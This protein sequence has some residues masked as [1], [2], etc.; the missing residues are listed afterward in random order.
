MLQALRAHSTRFRAAQLSSEALSRCYS[1][2]GDVDDKHNE[3]L[4]VWGDDSSASVVEQP[5]IPWVRSVISGVALL[6]HPKYNKGLA[7][8]NDERDKLYLRGLIPP[9]VL[10]LETQIQRVMINVRGMATDLERYN[11]LM[12][13][14]DRNERLCYIVIRQNLEEL[15][16]VVHLPTVRQACGKYG[17]MFRSIPKGL[18]LTQL[19]E[20]K[21]R[22]VLKNWPERHVKVVMITDGELVGPA[23]DLGVHAV[24]AAIS[25]LSLVTTIGGVTPGLCLPIMTDFGTNNEELL[26]SQFYVGLK[27]KRLTGDIPDQLMHELMDALE[28]RFGNHT[29]IF[30]EDMTYPNAQKLLSQYR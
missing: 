16:P 29:M 30:F 23:G 11:Y 14:Q 1:K 15:L 20:G 9:A 24:N 10:S 22:Q 17:L 28:K 6:R 8:E 5:M 18:F 27:H 19:D 26:K 12:S 25:K 2:R 4:H 21:V 7:F 13:L 3:S